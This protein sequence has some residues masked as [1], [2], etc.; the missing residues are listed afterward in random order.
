MPQFR[1]YFLDQTNENARLLRQH[2]QSKASL[3]WLVPPE[4]DPAAVHT[5]L[6]LACGPGAW[7]LDFA[8]TYPHAEVVGIDIAQVPLTEAR[9]LAKRENL[10]NAVF[11]EGDIT[12]QAGLPFPDNAF[13]LV[14]ARLVFLHLPR[15][16]WEPMLREIYRVLRPNGAFVVLDTDLT[17]GSFSNPAYRRIEALLAELLIKGGRMPRFGVL[18]PGLL[19]RAGFERI[20][21][22]LLLYPC[23]FQQGNQPVPEEI[24][25][26]QATS[27]GGFQN[28]RAALL[29]A[30]LVSA[31]EFDQLYEAACE[32]IE[33]NP[34]EVIIEL[35]FSVSGHKPT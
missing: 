20:W 13:D 16:T 33:N 24:R 27:L 22:R 4:I 9:R 28:A 14:W 32:Q 26:L 12:D 15:V 18:A 19:R 23:S 30:K 3:G 25:R 6:D 7:A 29:S 8:R 35:G 5:A 17:S 21:T 31:E 11:H 2:E 1:D 10:A 34:D